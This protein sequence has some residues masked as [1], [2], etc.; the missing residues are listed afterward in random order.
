MSGNDPNSTDLYR[1]LS[2][3]RDADALWKAQNVRGATSSRKITFAEQG[4]LEILVL[5]GAQPVPAIA[6][7]RMV[8]RQHIQKLVDDLGRKRLVELR[9]NPAHKTSPLVDVT[10]DGERAYTTAASREA[11]I[12]AAMAPDLAETDLR[13]ALAALRALVDALGAAR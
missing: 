10:I 2:L 1:L 6:R 9:P 5:D 8:S 12:L 11:E 7:R 13:P 4:I 3:T